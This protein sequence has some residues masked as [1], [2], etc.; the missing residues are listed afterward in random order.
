MIKRPEDLKAGINHAL[1]YGSEVLLEEY[2]KGREFT[3]TVME[4]EQIKALAVTE[5]IPL[6][7][8]FYDYKA[9]YEVGGSKHVC[10]A[11]I[12]QAEENKLKDYAIKVFKAIGC[13]G[14]ARADFI[15]DIEK[16]EFYFIELNTIPG[17]TAT[18]LAPEAA[19][20]AGYSFSGFL[21]ALI[22]NKLK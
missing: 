10:P 2:I 13:N 4:G 21:D 7:S 3:V 18:S 20:S 19:K 15:L 6:I 14:L 22:S 1:G 17:M 16:N 11:E 5:I 12:S 9:K 8:E